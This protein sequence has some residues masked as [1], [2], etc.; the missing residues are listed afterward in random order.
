MR[1]RAQ[2]VGRRAKQNSSLVSWRLN[3][4]SRICQVRCPGPAVLF[5]TEIRKDIREADL[6]QLLAPFFAIL[7]SPLSTGPISSAALASLHSFFVSGLITEDSPS[8][9]A[10]LSELSSTIA[11]CKFEASDSSGDEVVLLR[12][13]TVIQDSLCGS[14]GHGLGD[15][16][17]CEMLETV[18]TT[19][20]QMRLSGKH[21]ING[22][23]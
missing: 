4:G 15:I 22:P 11:H 2:K 18:L 17:V 10:A 16:E 6:T 7:R 21:T 20:C 1:S 19:C 13:M 14:V 8:I 3:G 9:T 5:L 12:I 23:N